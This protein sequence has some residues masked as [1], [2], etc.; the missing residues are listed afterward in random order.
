MIGL[1]GGLFSIGSGA[2]TTVKGA[3]VL[4]SSKD[5]NYSIADNYVCRKDFWDAH[6]D[7][8]YKVVAGRL[9]AQEEV[10]ELKKAYASSPNSAEAKKYKDLLQLAQNI[11]GKEAI[12]TLD[13]ADGLLSDC[14]FVG[15]PGNVAFFTQPN[16]PHGF[17]VMQKKILDIVTS[18]GYAKVRQAVAPSPIDWNN[19]AFNILKMKEVKR[20]E[21]IKAEAAVGEIEALTLGG[22]LD[23][24]TI[25]A[26][27][28]NF[29][30]NQTEFSEEQYGVEYQRVIDILGKSSN[31]VIAVRGNAD[32]T[33]VLAAVVKA[34]MAKDILKQS[35]TP[36]NYTYF[37]NNR[38]LDLTSTANII[39][40]ID[41]ADSPFDG[42]ADSNPREIMQ[43]A[44]NLS[45]QRAEAVRDSA[46]KFAKSK[47]VE[48]DKTQIQVFGV[49]IREPLIAKPRNMAEA[50]QNMRVEFRLVRVTAEAIN[51]SDFDF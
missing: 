36:G 28:I 25:L 11:W 51:P 12:P 14:T 47:G 26:F 13:D 49:G 3:H 44:V 46:I 45:R 41:A 6:S 42:V 40:L 22:A 2:E 48:I 27:S 8:V 18:R 43:A 16:N 5:L 4:V 39:K 7:V 9:K 1:T 34:G 29:K 21:R 10:I 32:P 23:E 37:M 17:D 20:T 35:G 30:T 33:K 24:R 19:P 50:E 15:H 31:A 38:P